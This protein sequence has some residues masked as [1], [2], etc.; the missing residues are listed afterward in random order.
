[1]PREE[2][3]ISCALFDMDGTLYDSEL[4]FH[5]LRRDLGLPTD[6]EPILVQLE[7]LP[8]RLRDA[9]VQR[10]HAAEEEAAGRGSLLPGAAELLAW[11]HE[12]AVLCALIT[13]NS[14]RSLDT[15]LRRLSLRFD[16]TL[17]RDDGPMKPD[18][19]LYIEALQRFGL[20]PDQAV[21]IG[22]SA[23]DARAAHAAGI[24]SIFLVHLSPLAARLVPAELPYVAA[25]SLDDVR[26][27]LQ[28]RWGSPSDRIT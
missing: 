13:N 1:M 28:A 25:D 10:L 21:A 15:V 24:R 9:G 23:L 18:P 2:A 16:L 4:S 5:A 19:A 6:G 3:A 7:R 20:S 27:H 17:S 22:D 12:Q 14:R 11:L 8:K 26:R